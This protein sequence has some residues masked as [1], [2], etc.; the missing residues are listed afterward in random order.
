[1][2][3]ECAAAALCPVTWPAG[4]WGGRA[5]LKE[6]EK[7]EAGSTRASFPAS[8]GDPFQPFHATALQVAGGK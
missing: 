2:C 6:G 1:M 8:P 4:C 3:N 5:R 7:L